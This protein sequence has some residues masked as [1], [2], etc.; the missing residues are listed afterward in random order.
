M[1]GSA[2]LDKAQ[3]FHAGK[4]SKAGTLGPRKPRLVNP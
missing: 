3:S 2:A 1:E 4:N